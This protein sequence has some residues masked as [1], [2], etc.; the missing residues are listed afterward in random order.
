MTP[1]SPIFVVPEPLDPSAETRLEA[2][3]RVER[4]GTD[5][6]AVLAAAA[7][8]D[9]L[10]VRTH[11]VVDD[12]LLDAAPKLRVVGRAGTGLDTIDVAACRRRSIEVVHTPEANVPAVVEYVTGA[13]LDHVRPRPAVPGGLDLA[14]WQAERRAATGRLQIHGSTVGILGC[15]RIGTRIARVFAAL[16]AE[17][18]QHDLRDIHA[19]DAGGA[20]PVDART[21]RRESEILTIHVDGRAS[22]RGLVGASE[23]A[24]MR[25]D[26]LLVNASRGFVVDT[27]A[28]AAFLGARPEAAAVID[29]HEPEPIASDHPLLACPNAVLTAHLA[30]RT[31]AAQRA[32]SDVVDDV[33]AVL[34]GRPPTFPAPPV[35][36]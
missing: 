15:G 28:L 36:E 33:I 13:V 19:V 11:V 21:L 18:I 22:N 16:G 1:P 30:S 14:A 29:V 2:R 6:S 10:V 26:V 24:E 31:E 3:G 34:D 12:E 25:D 17:V 27:P 7:D 9:A 32:M 23:L 5:R 4:P 8:A 35:S 20:R